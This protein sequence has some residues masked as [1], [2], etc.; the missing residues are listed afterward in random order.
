MVY[1]I[2]NGDSLTERF[3]ETNIEGEILIMKECMIEGDLRGDTLTEF[4]EHRTRFLANTYDAD[5][6]EYSISGLIGKILMAPDHS[7]FNLWFEY[8]LF[9]Q[10]NMWF[11]MSLMASFNSTI[12]VFITYSFWSTPAARCRG[13]GPATS[14]N[15]I[16][17]YSRRLRCEQKDLDLAVAL[18]DAYKINDLTAL[19]GLSSS[20]SICFPYLEEVCFA[21]IDRFG[22]NGEPGRPEKRI[23]AILKEFPTADFNKVFMEFTRWEGMYGFGDLQ[24]KHIYDNMD[25]P[26]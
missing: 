17:W 7:E 3:K 14:D 16:D 12:S 6:N 21:H 26:G 22:I 24:L 10:S 2:L 4:I 18:W 20:K 8:D 25:T 9:C 11:L 19:E 5:P 1:H 23:K 15:L 13:F